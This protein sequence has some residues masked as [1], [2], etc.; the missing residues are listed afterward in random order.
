[1]FLRNKNKIPNPVHNRQGGLCE[2]GAVYLGQVD[3]IEKAHVHGLKTTTTTAKA[4]KQTT[5]T[6]S[7][8]ELLYAIH[9]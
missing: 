1:M 5:T 7:V 4:S 3:E 8:C 9:H 2:R 6:G